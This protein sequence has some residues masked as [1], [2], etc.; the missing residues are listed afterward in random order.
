MNMDKWEETQYRKKVE[1]RFRG[2]WEEGLELVRT[3]PIKKRNEGALGKIYEWFFC[4]ETDEKK[5]REKVFGEKEVPFE[6]IKDCLGLFSEGWTLDEAVMWA[7]SL[8]LEEEERGIIKEFLGMGW[9]IVSEKEFDESEFLL[10]V[11]EEINDDIAVFYNEMVSTWA[12]W[13]WK[14]LKPALEKI[15]R[16][17]ENPKDH[18]DDSVYE[19]LKRSLLGAVQTQTSDRFNE[20]EGAEVIRSAAEKGWGPAIYEVALVG[21]GG[22]HPDTQKVSEVAQVIWKK[23]LSRNDVEVV[24]DSEDDHEE[25][26]EWD[27]LFVPSESLKK[28]VGSFINNPAT[29]ELDGIVTNEDPF[30]E[31]LDVLIEMTDSFLSK[32]VGDSLRDE[33]SRKKKVA[34]EEFDN[35]FY[36]SW[37]DPKNR[38]GK[39]V[40][41]ATGR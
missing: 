33:D 18:L 34:E 25:R 5:L 1:N 15:K 41:P 36:G 39:K 13:N 22:L 6:E 31:I 35:P 26:G 21:E 2:A 27:K 16:S 32:K 14:I 7:D 12:I 19:D 40:N 9:H 30:G 24:E 4:G 8:E 23:M 38:K 3:S 11:R 29:R 20:R 37:F 10:E 28:K 17:I